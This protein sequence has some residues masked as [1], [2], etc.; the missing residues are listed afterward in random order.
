MPQPPPA[1]GT[2][3]TPTA[4]QVKTDVGTSVSLLLGAFAVTA[5]MYSVLVLRGIDVPLLG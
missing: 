4:T 2:P 1:P 5:L 3:E